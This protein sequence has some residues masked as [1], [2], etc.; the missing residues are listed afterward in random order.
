MTGTDVNASVMIPKR[1]M[2]RLD[3]AAA[4]GSDCN[5]TAVTMAEELPPRVTPLVT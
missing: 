1:L 5:R 2:L 4:L 3:K